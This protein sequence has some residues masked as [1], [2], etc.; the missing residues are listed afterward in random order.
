MSGSKVSICRHEVRG[1]ETADILSPFPQH[2][3][4]TALGSSASTGEE[5]LTAE[6][7][8][9]ATYADLL[10]APDGALT[11][12]IAFISHNMQRTQDGSS[13]GYAG[14]ARWTAANIAA[15]KGA[16]GIVIRSVGTDYHR[17]PHAGGTSFEE[18]VV[19]IPA[20]AL[21]IP[22]AENLERILARGKPV[23]MRLKLTPA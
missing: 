8:Y 16:A 4:V 11:G 1:A 21:S 22:D 13:Y 10:A 5:G 3:H 7:A 17:N 9:F 19:P 6:I 18:G 23:T 15:K 2:M 20:G 14:P 12:K